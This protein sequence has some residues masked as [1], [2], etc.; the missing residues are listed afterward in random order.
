MAGAW[1]GDGWR[2]SY[3]RPPSSASNPQ[4]VKTENA[5]I[6]R[7]LRLFTMYFGEKPNT[8]EPLTANC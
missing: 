2:I 6:L 1:H 8:V 4:Y 7:I 5:K 3:L